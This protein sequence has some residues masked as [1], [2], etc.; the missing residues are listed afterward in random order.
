M[1]DIVVFL[2]RKVFI[3]VIFSKLKHFLDLRVLKNSQMMNFKYSFIG[4]QN[5]DKNLLS[6]PKC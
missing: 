3:S 6:E 1:E 2:T 4:K 5:I